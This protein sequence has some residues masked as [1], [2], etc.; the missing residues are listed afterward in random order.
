[1]GQTIYGEVESTAN[2]PG[3]Q[4]E[5][6]E[7]KVILGKKTKYLVILQVTDNSGKTGNPPFE[8]FVVQNGNGEPLVN[9]Q[10]DGQTPTGQNLEFSYLSFGFEPLDDQNSVTNQCTIKLSLA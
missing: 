6:V 9:A 1:M 7:F 2:L 8:F 10:F 3:L 5:L 4:Y